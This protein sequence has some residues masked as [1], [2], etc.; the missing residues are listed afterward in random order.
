MA[1]GLLRQMVGRRFQP[2]MNVGVRSSPQPTGLEA[3]LKQPCGAIA[4]RITPNVKPCHAAQLLRIAP[5]WFFC[6][7]IFG[8][9]KAS[10]CLVIAKNRPAKSRTRRTSPPGRAGAAFQDQRRLALTAF[11]LAGAMAT[12]FPI[13]DVQLLVRDAYPTDFREESDAAIV[14]YT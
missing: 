2:G 11:R 9:D 4:K 8:D 6:S 3:Q 1:D 5:Y 7:R 14:P 13:S 12:S 10:F